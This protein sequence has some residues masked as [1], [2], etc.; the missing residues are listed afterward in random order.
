MDATVA[1][2]ISAWLMVKFTVLVPVYLPM[3]VMVAVAVPAFTLLVYE[4]V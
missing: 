3:P 2:E 4:T 1:E